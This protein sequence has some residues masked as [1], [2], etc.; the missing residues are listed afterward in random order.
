MN[1]DNIVKVMCVDPDFDVEN[2]IAGRVSFLQYQLVKSGGTKLVLGISGGV[3]S[4]TAGILCQMAVD[5]MNLEGEGFEF[6][7]V[8]LPYGVQSD[9][10]DAQDAIDFIKPTRVVTA[11]ISSGTCGIHSDVLE[12]M[13]AAGMLPVG[14]GNLDFARGNVKARMRMIAQYEIA[15]LSNGRVVGTDHSAE[16]VTGFYTKFGDGACDFAPL[17]G[18]NKRQVRAIAEHLGAPDNLWTKEAMADLESCKPQQSDE[19][20]LGVTYQEIDDFLEGKQVHPE[21]AST[22][23]DRYTLT[24]HKRELPV[25]YES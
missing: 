17:F 14:S 7:A 23:I 11:N 9:E 22:I 16:S 2:E 6:I 20:S 5:S 4:T 24:Q 13:G 1:Q 21:A 8:R 19:D 3:D 12:G 15:G 25:A 10:S 18:L